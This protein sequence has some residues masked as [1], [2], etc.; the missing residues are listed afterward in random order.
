M[1]IDFDKNGQFNDIDSLLFLHYLGGLRGNA[2]VGGDLATFSLSATEIESSIEGFLNRESSVLDIDDDS[3]LNL[4]T[5]GFLVHR[6]VANVEG[7]ALINNALGASAK[8]QDAAKIDT[9]LDALRGLEKEDSKEIGNGNGFSGSDA[10]DIEWTYVDA[11]VN[12]TSDE[13]IFENVNVY[14]EISG[15]SADTEELQELE[16]N[17]DDISFFYTISEFGEDV[18]VNANGITIGELHLQ[19]PVDAFVV[20][21][22]LFLSEVFADF[23]QAEDSASY[24]I[25][26]SRL[27][28]DETGEP[29]VSNSDVILNYSSFEEISSSPPTSNAD[30]RR[31]TAPLLIEGE[32]KINRQFDDDWYR[33]DVAPGFENLTVDLSFNNNEGDID[34]ALYDANG[35]LVRSSTSATD[36]EQISMVVPNP[37]TYYIKAYYGDTGNEYE[38]QWLSSPTQTVELQLEP[39]GEEFKVNAQ[40]VTTSAVTNPDVAIAPNRDFVVVWQYPYSD[41]DTDLKFRRFNADG[42][43]KDSFDRALAD[44]SDNELNPSVA[45]ADDGSFVVAYEKRD[46]DGNL[47]MVVQHVDAAGNL[48]SEVHVESGQLGGSVNKVEE[49]EPDIAI[50]EDGSQF[51]V[52]WTGKA[53]SN[54]GDDSYIYRQDFSVDGSSISPQD[55]SDRIGFF[56]QPDDPAIALSPYGSVVIYT[57]SFS[58]SDFSETEYVYIIGNNGEYSFSIPAIPAGSSTTES[59]ESTSKSDIAVA[60]N[61]SFV[62]TWTHTDSEGN[63][64][65]RFRRFSAGGT[66]LDTADQ[67][68]DDSSGNQDHPVVAMTYDGQ[69]VVA[70]ENDLQEEILYRVFAADG[71]AL[72]SS[73]FYS[74]SLNVE[75]NPAIAIAPDGSQMV[76]VADDDGSHAF[77]PW[78]RIYANNNNPD[79]ISS[80]QS[81]SLAAN[82]QE[83]T[84]SD[85]LQSLNL[86]SDSPTSLNLAA[87]LAANQQ[88]I[89][90]SSDSLSVAPGTPLQFDVMYDADQTLGTLGLRLHFNSNQLTYN[91]LNNLLAANHLGRQIRNDTENFDGD[92]STDKYLLTLWADPLNE[93]FPGNFGSN[94]KARL[95]TANFTANSTFTGTTLKFTSSALAN[96]Y[97]LN[98]NPVTIT[99]ND[100]DGKRNILW[101]NTRDGR[102][103]VWEMD[104][105]NYL[106]SVQLTTV[107][108]QDWQLIG[109]ADFVG[110][111]DKDLLWR[112]TR[113]GRN[114][115]WEIDGTNYLRSVQLTT[116]SNQDW[117]LIGAADFVGNSDE[118]L[119]WRNTRDGRNVVWEMNGTNRIGGVSLT[120]VANQDWQLIGAADLVGNS[121]P[122]L[123]WR[124]TKDGRNI[125]W[126]MNDTTHISST[127]L[128]TVPDPN[129]SMIGFIV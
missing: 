10:R 12:V 17:D 126:E 123:L 40:T 8:R 65:I 21:E 119:L 110:N 121:D 75:D 91:S 74:A 32:Q 84:A 118:D 33:I 26:L 80:L 20:G 116:V 128:T 107:S 43:P 23:V 28:C 96:G 83:F 88:E 27:I 47:D 38:L 50:T 3:N 127:Q 95:Y 93:T 104:G 111:S 58:S 101:R 63:K 9:H 67:I 39:L 46:S 66:P 31:E 82:Q 89:T 129:W 42:T 13:V 112:N 29:C 99:Q 71:T 109:A 48:S 59:S 5:D 94:D 106:R 2:L 25:P 49:S 92:S 85:S 15:D 98:A 35:T 103:V 76:I 6:H 45:I 14:V 36:N 105:T 19:F 51:S 61:G 54:S 68:V 37:G 11:A 52:V 72:S 122:D 125:V 77:D 114:V 115:V 113:D 73:Q 18:S 41:T 4:A 69:F 7:N 86:A 78:A 124:N 56:N 22:P 108:N 70:Y 53:I 90:V 55:S 97:T 102:N 30:D 60:G 24:S 79:N 87:N 62:V 100:D 117:Q 120:T 57:R 16:A 64:D 44:R 34:L 81:L 1:A